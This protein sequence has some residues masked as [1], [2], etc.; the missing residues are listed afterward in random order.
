VHFVFYVVDFLLVLLDILTY[1]PDTE[2]NLK[3]DI[4]TCYCVCFNFTAGK[5]WSTEFWTWLWCAI[6][7]LESWN[8]AG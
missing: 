3:K 2:K 4:K 8:N 7:Y 1:K 6:R 5:N